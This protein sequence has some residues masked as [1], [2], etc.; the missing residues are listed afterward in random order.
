MKKKKSEFTRRQFLIAGSVAVAVPLVSDLSTSSRAAEA[1]NA[2]KSINSGRKIY[3]IGH[4]CIGCQTCRMFCPS[5][6]ID[7]GDSRNE[8]DQ[9]KCRSCGTCYRECPLSVI[10]EI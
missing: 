3:Y 1:T 6:A 8:I 2:K 4:D 5:N 9:E 7:Y 10:T